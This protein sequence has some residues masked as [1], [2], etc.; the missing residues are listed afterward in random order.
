MRLPSFTSFA[1][2]VGLALLAP[3]C[4]DDEAND[5]GTPGSQIPPDGPAYVVS[6]SIGTPD[7]SSSVF[8]VVPSLDASITADLSNNA[9]VG[10]FGVTLATD[11]QGTVFVGLGETPEIVRYTLTDAGVLEPGLRMSLQGRGFASSAAGKVVLVAPNKAYF[12]S[13]LEGRVIVW[14]PETMTITG[15]FSLDLPAIEGLN[16]ITAPDTIVFSDGRLTVP[17]L[18]WDEDGIVFGDR[19]ITSVIDTNT[20]TVVSTDED[21]RCGSA[22]FMH[23]T[24]DGT[25]YVGGHVPHEVYRLALGEAGGTEICHLRIVPPGGDFDDSFFVDL[26]SLTGG[27]PTGDFVLIDD[28]TAGILAF[29]EDEAT[30]FDDDVFDFAF[31][32]AYRWYL[33]NLDE[34][35]ATLIQTDD[36]GSPA[37]RRFLIDGT[38]Y[39][40]EEDRTGIDADGNPVATLLNITRDGQLQRGISVPGQIRNVLRIR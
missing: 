18:Y 11:A 33:W 5:D 4:G 32:N 38:W 26:S 35:D 20:D 1:A 34:S 6:I 39:F 15:E 40:Q 36:A 13:V 23:E 22:W 24:S 27:R 3:S 28:N 30:P 10:G 31:Q 16:A 8:A 2:T 9:S 25:Q 19:V 12:V 37:G 29:H 21:T 7:G 14:N 17:T